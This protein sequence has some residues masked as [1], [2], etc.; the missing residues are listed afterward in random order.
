MCT[1]AK[2][3]NLFENSN[4]Q[5]GPA[6]LRRRELKQKPVIIGAVSQDCKVKILLSPNQLA[7]TAAVGDSIRSGA[8]TA[9]STQ[10]GKRIE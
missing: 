8:A 4:L 5:S 10:F 6:T 2:T 3:N 1:L 9:S 7:N